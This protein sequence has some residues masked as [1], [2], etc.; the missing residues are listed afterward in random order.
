V[1]AKAIETLVRYFDSRRS[2]QSGAIPAESAAR[3][4]G[5][6][7]WSTS[8]LSLAIDLW[9]GAGKVPRELARKMRHSAAKTDQVF[10]KLAHDLTRS[11]KGFLSVAHTDTLEPQGNA[12]YTGPWGHA[13]PANL[14]LLRYRQVKLAGYRKLVLDAAAGYLNDEPKIQ[15]ALHPGALG[16]VVFLMLGAYELTGQ[17]EYLDRA[18]HFARKAIRLFLDDSSPLPKATSKH[19]HYEAV[20]GGDTLMM[21]LLKLWAT[22]NRPNM[23]LRLIYSDR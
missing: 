5:K 9:D 1:F 4:G 3:S 10:L 2:P 21:A 12:P 20:T 15:V 17:K 22:K 16:H 14:C 6:T 7:V 13:G 11:G 23:K 18:D 8:N 19:D